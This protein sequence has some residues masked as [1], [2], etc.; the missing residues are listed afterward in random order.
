M[1]GIRVRDI[2]M[3]NG[4]RMEKIMETVG[5][6]GARI[7]KEGSWDLSVYITKR[8]K[9]LCGLR[10]APVKPLAATLLWTLL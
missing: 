3:K 5:S 6:T 10:C 4:R 8:G 9:N 1:K 7:K 2:R